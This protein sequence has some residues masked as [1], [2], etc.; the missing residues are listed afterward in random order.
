MK[1]HIKEAVL[2]S[3]SPK[4]AQKE[5]LSDYLS[6]LEENHI[7]SQE[8]NVS[9]INV[10]NTIIDG[11]TEEA[12]KIMIKA[13]AL[14]FTFPLYVYCLPGMLMQFLQ[15][16]YCYYNEHGNKKAKVFAVVNCG[17][18]EPDINEEAV[19]VIKSFSEKIGMEFRF[20][21]LIGGGGMILGTK[22]APFMKKTMEILNS[23]FEKMKDDILENSPITCENIY[24]RVNFPRRLYFF[25][26]NLGWNSLT[27]K[28]GLKKK[29]LYR[30]PY[31]E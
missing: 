19:R 9:R 27:R 12:Y 16:Y 28:N 5:A 11:S 23:S 14:V 24:V 22:E 6:L 21:V 13:D 1:E 7:K 17:F 3:A 15:E 29:D 10:R 30:K 20:G 8:I 2:I 26:G 4:A 18:P 25:M 31:H